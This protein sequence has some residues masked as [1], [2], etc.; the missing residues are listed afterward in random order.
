MN[1]SFFPKTINLIIQ[2]PLYLLQTLPEILSALS[3]KLRNPGDF[4]EL[5]GIWKCNL[6]LYS[7]KTKKNQLSTFFKTWGKMRS[8][9]RAKFKNPKISLQIRKNL[10]LQPKPNTQKILIQI[11]W[12]DCEKLRLN[13]SFTVENKI[14]N[15][16]KLRL[17][18]FQT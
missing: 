18:T 11:L 3:N 14:G 16:H 7:K 17:F 13:L 1:I 10:E 6:D 8:P 12:L 2:V 5:G 9:D 4:S 15:L